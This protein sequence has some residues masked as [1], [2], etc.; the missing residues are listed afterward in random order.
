MQTSNCTTEDSFL[1]EIL[2]NLFGYDSVFF[3]K[4]HPYHHPD[5]IL[6]EL[7]N[8]SLRFLQYVKKLDSYPN[9]LKRQYQEQQQSL[10]A[11]YHDVLPKVFYQTFTANHLQFT[12]IRSNSLIQSLLN[13]FH[14][15]IT[16]VYLLRTWSQ[17]KFV[18]LPP[19]NINANLNE[20]GFIPRSL[21]NEDDYNRRQVLLE[22]G[23][24]GGE[25]IFVIKSAIQRVLLA[26]EQELHVI[27]L[28]VKQVPS[29][30]EQIHT[31]SPSQSSFLPPRKKRSITLLTFYQRCRQYDD[32]LVS[33]LGM[34][35]NFHDNYDVFL[36]PQITTNNLTSDS[37]NNVI[38][39]DFLQ[40]YLNQISFLHQ[41]QVILIKGQVMEYH[42]TLRNPTST[43]IMKLSF[44]EGRLCKR[45][46]FYLFM[47][48]LFVEYVSTFTQQ[49]MKAIW[50]NSRK[51]TI[52]HNLP[53]LLLSSLV[54]SSS[55]YGNHNNYL[56][57]AVNDRNI[58][59]LKE[60]S[61][62]ESNYG[63]TV[64]PSLFFLL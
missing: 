22:H 45:Q 27:E 61:K 5:Q 10:F 8:T 41:S 57:S 30:A 53:I 28:Q 32:L 56:S 37:D 49:I 42:P 9:E 14:Q 38:R 19:S 44:D 3:Q 52:T 16:I 55:Y 50:L 64:Y 46:Y 21:G 48:Q 23:G 59:I 63:K 51:V 18:I 39:S 25:E 11:L 54:N 62:Y 7:A 47:K 35:F 6:Q 17:S 34:I 20:G 33:L 1:Q 13:Y 31:P 12:T 24:H 2:H 60:L 58:Q 29:L 4:I 43:G 36:P 15:L 40:R 26:L